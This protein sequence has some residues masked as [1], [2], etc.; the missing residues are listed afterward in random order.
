MGKKPKRKNT[1]DG[2]LMDAN[3][4]EE[5]WHDTR[6]AHPEPVVEMCGLRAAIS[7]RACGIS[8]RLLMRFGHEKTFDVHMFDGFETPVGRASARGAGRFIFGKASRVVTPD[9]GLGQ[10]DRPLFDM[11]M[12]AILMDTLTIDER[13]MLLREPAKDF[14]AMWRGIDCPHKHAVC[15][16]YG[17]QLNIVCSDCA[18]IMSF[19]LIDGDTFTASVTRRPLKPVQCGPHGAEAVVR[20]VREHAG[21]LGLP[22]MM[23]DRMSDDPERDARQIAG[24][25][26]LLERHGL[27]GRHGG[28]M[29]L[30]YGDAVRELSAMSCTRAEFAE[31]SVR[32]EAAM[33]AA[34][35]G[36]TED[37]RPIEYAQMMETMRLTWPCLFRGNGIDVDVFDPTGFSQFCVRCGFATMDDAGAGP[38]LWKD[39]CPKCGYAGYLLGVD[40]RAGAVSDA[41][42]Q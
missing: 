29:G 8:M 13:K 32:V 6:C 15:Q 36:C 22:V 35:V 9:G 38:G 26:S 2:A 37:G 23:A 25:V 33:R 11:E 3:A 17:N 34:N 16:A 1:A 42:T 40:G 18:S 14:D 20:A 4:L 28:A 30:P 5:V 24:L 27:L 7:C 31:R 41:A 21:V 12:S 39:G 19:G 10:C